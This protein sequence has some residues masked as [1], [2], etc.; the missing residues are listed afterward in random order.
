M[1]LQTLYQ[2]AIKF[3]GE[4]HENQK[5]PG[6]QSSYLVHLSNVAMEIM[7]AAQHTD[8]F[9]E[10][11]ALQVALLHDVLE[12][13]TTTFDELKAAF[14]HKI[15]DAILALSKDE[16]LEAE[17]RIPDSLER[18]KLQPKEVW[19]VKLADRI[20]NM[21][22]PPAHWDKNKRMTYLKMAG[23]ILFELK[24]GNAYLENRLEEK[25]IDYQAYISVDGS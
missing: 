3:A 19:A 13:T 7:I 4:K 18:I 5:V 2:K 20:T 17:A 1:D 6:S 11:F 10:G 22:E 8:N 21:Q 9:D 15:A 16:V 14:G 25:I 24:G 23:I 12:D